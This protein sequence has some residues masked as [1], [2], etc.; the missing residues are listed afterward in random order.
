MFGIDS[1]F[2]IPIVAIIAWAA[3][4]IATVTSESNPPVE[5]NSTTTS[6]LKAVVR[7]AIE[8]A[9]APLL[10]RIDRLEQEVKQLPPAPADASPER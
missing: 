3:V 7:Q 4:R 2:L 10:A 8:E 9:N 1:V 5:A 6:E